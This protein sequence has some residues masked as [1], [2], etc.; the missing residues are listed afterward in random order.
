MNE[1]NE[2]KMGWQICQLF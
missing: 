2:K 1:M